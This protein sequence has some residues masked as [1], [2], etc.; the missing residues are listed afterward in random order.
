VGF[1]DIFYRK[2]TPGKLL[3]RNQQVRGSSPRAGKSKLDQYRPE[4]EALMEN[5][6]TQRYIA[7][8]YGCS[9]ANLLNWLRKNKID[10]APSLQN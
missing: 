9:E 7:K 4:I 6:S 2:G 5:G 1:Q 10:R 3:I 8:R